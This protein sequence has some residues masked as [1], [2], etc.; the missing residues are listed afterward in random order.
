MRRDRALLQALAGVAG[1]TL[2]ALLLFSLAAYALLSAT[3]PDPEQAALAAMLGGR[4]PLLLLAACGLAAL[5]AGA[6]QPLVRRWVTA[7]ARLLEQGQVLLAT[8]VQRP[9]MATGAAVPV[10]GL[11]RLVND[12]A[13]Q[14]DRLKAD[15]AG[16]VAEASRGVAQ[17]RNR[18]AALMSELT[19]SVVVCNLDGR[20]LLY[21]NRARLQFRALSDAPQLAGGAELIGLG[22]SVYTVFDRKLVAHA[23]DSVQ[24]R[25]QRGV[26]HPSAQFVTVTRSGQLLRVQLAPV[27]GVADAEAGEAGAAVTGFVLMLDNITRSHEEEAA[28]ERLLHGLTEGSR[29]SL[30][31]LQA[32]L[33]MLDDADLPALEAA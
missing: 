19:Q 2:A 32:A 12:L 33:E 4:W 29:G 24:Q 14:R 17:E 6:S 25:L 23:M 13:A 7:P 3:L 16:A 18:L 28:Q 1:A 22:R 20:I 8:D 30:A 15:I 27:R 26:A 9:L 31:N 11:A 21:N 5:A 10:Q